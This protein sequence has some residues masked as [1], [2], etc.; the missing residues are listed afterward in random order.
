MLPRAALTPTT[1][2][3]RLSASGAQRN[4]NPVGILLERLDQPQDSVSVPLHGY[5]DDLPRLKTELETYALGEGRL[6][7]DCRNDD[8]HVLLAVIGLLGQ[9]YGFVLFGV[10]RYDGLVATFHALR[11]ELVT[12]QTVVCVKR[13]HLPQNS[14]S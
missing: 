10:V 14:E 6:G 12:T 3:M 1:N 4:D 8:A 9:R 13:R 5:D 11:V 7:V 2:R